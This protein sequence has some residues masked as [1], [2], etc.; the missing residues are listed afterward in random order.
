MF[1]TGIC[2]FF[3]C[4]LLFR[5]LHGQGNP[6]AFQIHIQHPDLYNIAHLYR[7][8]RMAD[9]AVANLRNM[10]QTVFMHT[11][12]H[13][14]AKVNDVSYCSYQLHARLQVL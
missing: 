7:F 2:P 12:I 4:R 13:K 8:Q 9:K 3:F 11:Y 10:H 6:L 1:C 5:F 14:A